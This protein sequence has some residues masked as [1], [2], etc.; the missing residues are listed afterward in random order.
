MRYA[1]LL[2][3]LCAKTFSVDSKYNCLALFV[4]RLIIPR[5]VESSRR[6]NAII[7]CCTHTYM[8]YII[9]CLLHIL[10]SDD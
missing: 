7:I 3:I 10:Q 4:L 2:C 6:Y 8:L 5:Y 9:E 1:N